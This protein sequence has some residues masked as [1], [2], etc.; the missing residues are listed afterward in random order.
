MCEDTFLGTYLPGQF[1]ISFHE[2]K[3]LMLLKVQLNFVG[4]GE[5]M[6]F[7]FLI[8]SFRIRG[9][10]LSCTWSKSGQLEVHLEGLFS[11]FH[12]NSYQR[13][14]EIFSCKK[15]RSRL[16][17]ISLDYYS[18]R[19]ILSTRQTNFS[20]KRI[21][22]NQL[23]SSWSYR[24]T[25]SFETYFGGKEKMWRIIFRKKKESSYCWRFF[26]F[27]SFFSFTLFWY[28]NLFNN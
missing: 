24:W 8:F 11:Y 14:W 16:S 5:S 12:S 7:C 4:S 27:C 2:Y 20:I 6:L 17:R 10:G 23:G 15:T 18:R 21:S 9:L 26:T 13:K 3:V 25:T 28:T 1:D 22:N 19:S